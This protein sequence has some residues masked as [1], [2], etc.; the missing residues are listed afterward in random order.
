MRHNLKWIQRATVWK[1]NNNLLIVL[2]LLRTITLCCLLSFNVGKQDVKET[3]KEP[4]EK[5][6]RLSYGAL[7][8]RGLK[9][10]CSVPCVENA[11]TFT[12]CLGP[13]GCS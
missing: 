5:I 3:H 10:F 4:N 13:A 8:K 12:K 2:K 6:I 9:K 7:D 11:L 1:E